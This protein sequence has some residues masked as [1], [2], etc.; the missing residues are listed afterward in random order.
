MTTELSQAIQPKSA[1]AAVALS[2]LNFQLPPF[3][4]VASK[5]VVKLTEQDVDTR[6][7]IELIEC[8]PT[9]FSKVLNLANSP[10][11]ATSRVITTV[12]HAVVL[13]GLNS[14]SQLALA[15]AT[16]AIFQDDGPTRDLRAETYSQSLAIATVAR[17]IARQSRKV[18]PDEAFL[19]GVAHDVG[20]LVLLD[21][22]GDAYVDLLKKTSAS[23]TPLAEQQAFGATHPDL[24]NCCAKSWGLPHSINEA[25]QNHHQP[26]D[27][28]DDP[29]SQVIIEANELARRWQL[30]FESS[31][32]VD[33][34]DIDERLD[35]E[36]K[37]VCE[38]QFAAIRDTCLS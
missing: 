11:Y 19:C 27:S 21:K 7:I 36:T 14:V 35:S 31:D 34:I 13:L 5:L 33:A 20:K 24:G 22:A 37:A 25:I 1:Y 28:V 23:K 12:G 38:E 30:G 18:N 6:S 15:V 2:E 26:L 29:L 9:V 17:V 4:S 16:G 10:M 32:D 3:P 8:E